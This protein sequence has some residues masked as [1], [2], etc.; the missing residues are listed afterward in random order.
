MNP[1]DSPKRRTK[2]T[3]AI[4]HLPDDDICSAMIVIPHLLVECL[5]LHSATCQ[6]AKRIGGGIFCQHPRKRDIAARTEA[7][8]RAKK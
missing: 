1:G 2:Q 8:K 3:H 7:K 4:R 5:V 6:H